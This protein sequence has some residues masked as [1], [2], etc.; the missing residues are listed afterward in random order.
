MDLIQRVLFLTFD[1]FSYF[2]KT[3]YSSCEHEYCKINVLHEL[4]RRYNIDIQNVL[5]VGDS[6]A[7][8]CMIQAAGIGVAFC[9]DN[10]V[11]QSIADYC[12]T[13]PSFRPL[14][15]FIT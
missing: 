6:S 1:L 12:I 13:E 5:A 9:S 15:Q 14:L 2:L 11:L 10:K 7:D 4:T 8:I 3:K